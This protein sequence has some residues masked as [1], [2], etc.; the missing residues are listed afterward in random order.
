MT[1]GPYSI[2]S[3]RWPGLA[4]MA[5]ECAEA[6]QVAM[7]IVAA[8]GESAYWDGSDLRQRL[9]DEI[10]DVCAAVDFLILAN[11]LDQDRI[12]QRAGGKLALFQGWHREHGDGS[13]TG[14][15]TGTEGDGDH[16]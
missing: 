14:T 16:D 15:I 1:A 10:A 3:D 4:K 6:I 11:G 5:E 7:K 9:E 2:G 12:R 8:N 13:I